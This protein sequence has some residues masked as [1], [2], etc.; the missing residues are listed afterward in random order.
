MESQPVIEK[1]KRPL[2]LSYFKPEEYKDYCERVL[3]A[4]ASYAFIFAI[5]KTLYG[6]GRPIQHDLD[7]ITV[8]EYSKMIESLEQKFDRMKHSEPGSMGVDCLENLD[9]EIESICTRLSIN[10]DSVKHNF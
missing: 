5:L 7:V 6:Y 1:S 8:A 3:V 10:I 9:K 4:G 2:Y